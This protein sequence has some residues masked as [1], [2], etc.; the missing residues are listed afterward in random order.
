MKKEHLEQCFPILTEYL[1]YLEVIKGRSA[2]TVEEYFL[3]LRT[4]FRFMKRHKLQ[5]PD[6]TPDEQISL[7]DIDLSFVK[8]ITQMDIFLYM[9]YA[10]ND[11]ENSNKTRARKTTSLRSFFRYLTDYAHLL[12]QNPTADLSQPKLKKSLPQ[13]LS[14]EQSLELLHAVHGEFAQRDY[15]MLTL[16]LNCGLRRAELAALNLT[17]IRADHTLRVLGKGNKERV[18]YLNDACQQALAAYLPTRP[19]DGVPAKDKNALFLSR[20]KQRITPQGVYYVVKGYLKQ[21]PGAENYSTHKLRHTAATLMYQQGNVDIRVL[22]EI[23]GHENLG[24][25][26]IYTHLSGSQLQQAV[27]SNPLAHVSPRPVEKSDKKSE[28][29]K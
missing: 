16:F 3:D 19:V 8:S 22:Q 10:K 1:T 27:Q 29:N 28:K 4:F 7:L 5:I 9:N 21:V 12:T 18:L 6:D 25:T 24:T 11:R 14:L 20:L 15:C 2:L 26:E 23:L 17:D 13:Y